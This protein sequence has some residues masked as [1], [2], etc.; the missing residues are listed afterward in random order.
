[1]SDLLPY[2]LD[3]AN[4]SLDYIA[5]F[6]S[7][8]GSFMWIKQRLQDI[9]VFQLKI[10]KDDKILLEMIASRLGLKERIYEYTHQGRSYAML[11]VRRRKTIKE[12]IIPTFDQR[13]FGTK[14]EQFDKW[15]DRYNLESLNF[16]YKPDPAPTYVGAGY[17]GG[18]FSSGIG[19]ADTLS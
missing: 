11:L 7:S 17:L 8:A 2:N 6:I 18:F 1:M 5:G 12:V 4:L 19:S 14:K 16:R 15:R 10:E 9:P 13:L 3:A